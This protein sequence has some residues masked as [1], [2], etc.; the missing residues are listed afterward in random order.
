MKIFVLVL[1]MILLLSVPWSASGAYIIQQ[2]QDV[3]IG[4]QGLDITATGVTSGG[5]VSWYSDTGT[6]GATAPASSITVGDASSFYVAP[7]DFT[8]KLGNWYIGTSPTL[9][10]RVRDP[11]LEIKVWD[12]SSQK[13]VT[14]KQVPVG[15]TLNF[16]LETNMY[17]MSQRPDFGSAQNDIRIKVKTPDGTVYSALFNT[18][19]SSTSLVNLHVNANP[20]YW[21]LV[22]N[23]MLGWKTDVTDSGGTRM[24]NPGTYTVWAESNVNRMKDNYKDPSGADYTGKTVSA[25]RTVTIAPDFIIIE[26]S[27]NHVVRGSPFSMTVRGSPLKSYYIWVRSTASMSGSAGD[28]PPEIDRDQDGVAMDIPAGTST[29]IGDYQFEGGGGRSIKND[30]PA[31]PMSGSVY[32][33]RITLS[34]SGSRTVGFSTSNSTKEGQYTIRVESGSPGYFLSDEADIAVEKGVVTLSSWPGERFYYGDDV[35]FSGVNSETDTVYLFMTGPD[36]PAG[37][38]PLTDPGTPVTDWQP[39]TFTRADVLADNTWQYTWQTAYLGIPTGPYEVWAVSTPN[40]Y[41]HLA[42]ATYA[43]LPLELVKPVLYAFGPS[44]LARGDTFSIGGIATGKSP[45]GVA[46]WIFGDTHASLQGRNVRQDSTFSFEIPGTGTEDMSDGEYYAIIQHPMMDGMFNV[47]AFNGKVYTYTPPGPPDVLFNLSGPGSLHG[48]AAALRVIEA[49]NDPGSDDICVSQNFTVED[50]VI[51]IDPVPDHQTGESIV[52]EG[53]TNLAAGNQLKIEI[54]LKPQTG[55]GHTGTSGIV[56]VVGMQGGDNRWTFPFN[57]IPYPPGTYHV[58]VSAVLVNVSAETEFNLTGTSA[59]VADFTASPRAGYPPLTVRFVDLSSNA[60][61]HWYWNFGDGNYSFEQSPS[62]TYHMPGMYN[63]SLTAANGMWYN[64]T[65]KPNFIS[66]TYSGPYIL[67]LRAGW[68]FVSVPRRLAPGNNTAA[69]VFGTVNTSGHSI[70]TYN[71]GWRQL[72]AGDIIRPLDA[73]WIYS[74]GDADLVL[75]FDTDPL[76]SPPT[77]SLP[78]GW[79]AIGFADTTPA[80]ARDAV[81]SV[82]GSWATLIGFD[83]AG[84]RYETSVIRGGSGAH[85]D[86]TLMY[87][88][89]GYWL[90]M[91]GPGELA[92]I[93]S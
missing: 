45:M 80:A 16:R 52:I 35:T 10:F 64:T 53:T 67:P 75:R 34:N 83:P 40:S 36:L 17:T 7:P 79:N 26:A 46:L 9:A 21:V 22:N 86:A 82:G 76:S 14:G 51:H 88:G 63:V 42:G 44:V 71:P 49:V 25:T 37:G 50:P 70:F 92:A 62:H 89:R 33:G 74:A 61:L 24:Y 32:Y 77:R 91:T 27:T 20:F 60:P 11:S 69:V 6:P 73:Y 81:M 47:Y 54:L 2:G 4:E 15:D 58:N 39:S 66:V 18:T 1:G 93:G 8:G 90:F 31:S 65:E 48:E 3:F 38:V 85:S 30:V 28:Q 55:S 5:S 12:Q 19:T 87:P 84:Q 43:G 29:G 57:A 59:P 78:A 68:N 41:Q 72:L 56:T 13:D 23:P